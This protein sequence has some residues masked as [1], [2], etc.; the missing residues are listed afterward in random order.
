VA[1]ACPAFEVGPGSS[2]GCS[3]ESGYLQSEY[4]EADE[5]INPHEIESGHTLSAFLIALVVVAPLVFLFHF[6]LY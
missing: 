6:L 3:R 5:D 1:L 2:F 4:A